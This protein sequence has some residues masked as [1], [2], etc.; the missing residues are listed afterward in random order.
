[1]RLFQHT[2][3]LNICLIIWLGFGTQAQQK[4]PSNNNKNNNNN[5]KNNNSKYVSNNND[6]NNNSN[7]NNS[8]YNSIIPANLFRS[9]GKRPDGAT[10]IPWIGGKYLTWDATVVHTCA[11]SFIRVSSVGQPAVKFKSTKAFLH[12]ICFSQWPSRL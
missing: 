8:K 2:D 7:N 4:L 6:N 1:M 5:S 3:L 11:A 9:D 10:L 12:P